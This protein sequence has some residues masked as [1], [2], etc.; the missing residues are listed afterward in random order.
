M[1]PSLRFNSCIGAYPG[2]LL[3]AK[4]FERISL[5]ISY[6]KPCNDPIAKQPSARGRWLQPPPTTSLWVAYAELKEVLWPFWPE[7]QKS[8][9]PAWPQ[10]PRES[11]ESPNQGN[12]P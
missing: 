11:V 9:R 8:T 2:V 3:T 1:F 6:D 7:F 10:K 12:C 4:Q 5:H